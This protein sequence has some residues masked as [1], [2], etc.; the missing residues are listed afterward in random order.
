MNVRPTAFF[1]T[2]CNIDSG[3]VH[4]LYS[5]AQDGFESTKMYAVSE[6]ELLGM[7]DRMPGCHRG[8]FALYE[9]MKTAAK[10][11]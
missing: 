3:G 9:M 7:T 1:F 8:G 11:S 4:E 2:K 10:K 5:R 6:E